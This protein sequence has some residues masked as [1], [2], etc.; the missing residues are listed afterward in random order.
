MINTKL[1]KLYRQYWGNI[2][3][4]KKAHPKLSGP[5]LMK[6]KDC[7]SKQKIKLFIVGQETR[8]WAS[9]ESVEKQGKVYEEFDFGIDYQYKGSPFWKAVRT[10]EKDFGISEGCIAW[11]NLNRMDFDGVCPEKDIE[12]KM[13]TE[14]SLLWQEIEIC[15]PDIVIFFTGPYYDYLIE[16]N[17]RK[18]KPSKVNKH[19]NER[20]LMQLK[21]PGIHARAYRT[22]HPNYLSRKKLTKKILKIITTNF[23]GYMD[24]P[25][26]PD[27]TKWRP[28]KDRESIK[29]LEF[30][31][32]YLIAQSDKKLDN[33]HVDPL[34]EKIIYIGETG[35]KLKKRLSQFES[36]SEGGSG[37]HYGGKTYLKESKKK[38][39]TKKNLFVA[40]H[41]C[42]A[43]KTKEEIK[44][45]LRMQEKKLIWDFI[46]EHGC[47]PA[48]N[49]PVIPKGAF[50]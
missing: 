43:K 47:Q 19:F 44:H 12:K 34:Y 46:T 42:K 48:C 4:F 23:Q 26:E 15:K 39:W 10:L 1:F 36:A 41:S 22:Y 21:L 38:G 33:R 32:V 24:F 11:S 29:E 45:F 27:F 50:L 28:L 31:G 9:K 14:F 37:S 7:Y 18:Y 30:P 40:V 6:I 5:L 17:F 35:S 16:D 2:T 49:K 20:Q 3:R 13:I 8:G 25:S